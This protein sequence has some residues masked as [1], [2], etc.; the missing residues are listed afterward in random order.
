MSES[1]ELRA[2]IAAN[3]AFYAAL[4]DGDFDAMDALWATAAPVL[5][6]HPG[7]AVLHGRHSVMESWRGILTQPPPIRE[8]S[9]QVALV[10][11]IAIVSCIEHIGEGSLAASNVFVWED[12][13]WRLV[14]HH[15][16]PLDQ[17]EPEASPQGRGHLH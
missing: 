17:S 8:S 2:A 12:A 16:G 5:C 9:V 7:A 15:A 6:A 4:A 14:H 3:R 11:G 1:N 13:A 10:R